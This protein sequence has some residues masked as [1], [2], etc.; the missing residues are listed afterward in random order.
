VVLARGNGIRLATLRNST[1]LLE[2]VVV[3]KKMLQH[4]KYFKKKTCLFGAVKSSADN[5]LVHPVAPSSSRESTI[6]PETAQVAA[7]KQ[8]LG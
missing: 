6:A 7:G 2:V 5:S 4:I 1:N 3:L 8:I